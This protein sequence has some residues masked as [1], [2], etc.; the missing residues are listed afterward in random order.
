[1]QYAKQLVGDQQAEV[2]GQGRSRTYNEALGDSLNWSCFQNEGNLDEIGELAVYYNCGVAWTKI[3]NYFQPF[4]H[5]V[6]DL[7]SPISF[8]LSVPKAP[9]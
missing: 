8:W 1:M 3:C 4:L 7:V 5:T 2:K 9:N 6:C